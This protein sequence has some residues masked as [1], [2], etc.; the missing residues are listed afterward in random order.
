MVTSGGVEQ[1]AARAAGMGGDG[2]IG[3]ELGRP[4]S[5]AIELIRLLDESGWWCGHVHV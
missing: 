3:S 1:A 4:V 5:T 2:N